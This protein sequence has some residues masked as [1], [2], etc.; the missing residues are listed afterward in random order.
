M[1]TYLCDHA[2]LD[3]KGDTPYSKHYEDIYWNRAGATQEKKHVFIKPLMQHLSVRCANQ[4]VTVCELGFGFGINCLLAAQYWRCQP[5]NSR[6]NLVSIERHPVGSLVLRKFLNQH[7]F[8]H[9]ENL[10]RQYPLP[11][12]GQH[13]IWLADNIRLLLIF[14]DVETALAGLD[15]A[16]DFWFLDGFSPKSNEAMWQD[17]LFRKMFARSRPGA[18]I[19]TYTAASH[20]RRGLEG[21]GFK[22]RK[23]LGFAEK[24]EMLQAT[25]PGKWRAAKIK[26]SS[27]TIIGSGLAGLYC[28]E[29]LEK[30]GIVPKIISSGIGASEIPQ[31]AVKPQIAVRAEARYRYSLMAFHYMKSSP[32]YHHTGLKWFA[33]NSEEKVRLR[34]I[35][36]Q[37]PNAIMFYHPEGM[38]E[39]AEAGWLSYDKL[40]ASISTTITVDE[41]S[42]LTATSGGWTLIG[43][44]KQYSAD[45][46]ILATGFDKRLLHPELQIRTIHGQAIS[47]G[48][49]RVNQILNGDVSVLPTDAGRSVISGTYARRNSLDANPEDT[50][51][52]LA[53]ALKLVSFDDSNISIYT[54]VRAVTRDRLP[55]IGAAPIWRKLDTVKRAN[56]IKAHATGLYYCVGF[57]SRGATH[58]RLSA[59][60]LVA[61]IFDEPAALDAKQQQMLS[62]ARFLLRDRA[63]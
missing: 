47:V 7:D 50:K 33:R 17:S 41:I 53:S 1:E 3:W 44:N 40:R 57:G 39:V 34:K 9:T 11:Y 2:Q 45:R 46:V 49:A 22:T 58:A 10:M 20:V 6:L 43:K 19:A 13:V 12:R 27:V 28:S 32:G 59:E 30:R 16:V 36:D 42:G 31:L 8:Y 55:I 18:G 51:K 26:P 61:K 25:A 48:T 5:A 15:A 52:L 23:K 63:Y 54:G 4:Q 14:N 60:N 35:A 62:P 29:A 37:F 21:A 24:K 38:I 56:D